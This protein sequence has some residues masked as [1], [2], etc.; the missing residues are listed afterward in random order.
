METFT[1]S[2]ELVENPHFA[3]QR[4][5]CLAGLGDSMIDAPIVDVVRAFNGLSCCFTLQSCYGHF[6]Y[7]DRS[8]PHNL[9]S[10]PDTDAITRV[11]YRIAYLA[12]CVEDSESGRALLDA[13][14]EVPS[15][16]P[17][18]IQFGCAE[19][20]WERQVDSY[21]LQVEPSRFK[22]QDKA[23]LGYQEALKIQALRG[24]FFGHVKDLPARQ[25]GGGL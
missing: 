7:P 15:L 11:K 5:E 2:K 20:F 6:V 24:V 19:W 13:L 21:V 10:L 17:D 9:E 14:A 23:I 4:R 12:L 22:F 8:D 1:E 18:N 3:Q 16:D 25:Q